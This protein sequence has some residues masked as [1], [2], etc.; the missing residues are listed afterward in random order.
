MKTIDIRLKPSEIASLKSIVGKQLISINHDP[1]V[2]SNTS[3]Q[4]VQINTNSDTFYLYSFTEPIDHFGA[5]EDVAVWSFESERYRSV[6]RKKFIE[7]PFKETIKSV[8]VIQENQQLC[9]SDEILY[10]V[11]LT[12]GII[13][14]FGEHQLSFE[15]SVWFSEDIRIQKGY[16]LINKFTPVADFVNDDWDKGITAKCTRE[17]ITLD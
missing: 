10:D 17:I 15:K 16:E 7:T 13:I 2:F 4:I 6:D 14:D 9:K 1:F 12:R 3:S 5:T 8:S 11:W